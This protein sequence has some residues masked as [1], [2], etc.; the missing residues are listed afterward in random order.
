MGECMRVKEISNHA[1]QQYSKRV[2]GVERELRG[3]EEYNHIRKIMLEDIT[4][5]HKN[6][7][8]LGSGEFRT[9]DC[10]YCMQDGVITTVK[11]VIKEE[12][13]MVSGG[14]MRSGKKIKKLIKSEVGPRVHPKP[15]YKKER[16]EK[17][18]NS[19]DVVS[20]ILNGW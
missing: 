7:L 4:A 1:C 3:R 16:N 11:V 9:N 8:M 20:N 5:T 12:R 17:I 14:I 15:N 10:T 6:V 13:S 19:L 2:L 18:T